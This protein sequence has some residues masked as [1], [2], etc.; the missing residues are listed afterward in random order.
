MLPPNESP[1]WPFLREFLRVAS[2]LIFGGL[3]YDQ[4]AANKDLLMLFLFA[5][6]SGS[7]TTVSEMLSRKNA[8]TEEEKKDQP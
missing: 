4:F 6:A 2:L 8:K 1:F 7:I 3:I 5:L